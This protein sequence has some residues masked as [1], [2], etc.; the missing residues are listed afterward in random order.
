MLTTNVTG[1]ALKKMFGEAEWVLW[2]A[3]F[4]SLPALVA[5]VLQYP[6]KLIADRAGKLPLMLV[7][8]SGFVGVSGLV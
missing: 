6:F 1:V 8:L 7:G 4:V 3:M 5:A 2:G